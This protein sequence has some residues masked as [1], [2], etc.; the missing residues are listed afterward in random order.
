MST[1][2]RT[3]LLLLCPLMTLGYSQALRSQ[4]RAAEEAEIDVELMHS[5]Q[6]INLP[7]STTLQKGEMEF[8]I[9][10]RFLPLT[11]EGKDRFW[12]LDGPVNMRIGLGWALRNNLVAT[13]ARSNVEDN[14][15]L[16]VK[17]RAIQIRHDLFPI[18]LALQGGTSWN[19]EVIGR[20]KMDWK[21]VQYYGHLV[22]NTLIKKRL[23]LGFVPSYLYNSHI[24]CPHY[25][26]S[27]TLGSY[28]QFYLSPYISFL[29]EWNPTLDG[30]RDRYNPVSFGIEMETGGH[31]FKIVLTNSMVMNAS[32]FLAGA[33]QSAQ[34][35]DW[36]IGFMIT[37][38][39]KLHKPQ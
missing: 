11:S 32:Q 30:W 28:L 20:K 23:G 22:I 17:Y 31:F 9:S 27:F 18:V 21:N 10:H 15:D 38:L 25:Q 7:T 6:A 33:D 16:H 14:I 24:Y 5:Q 2:F 29:A 35:N 3:L 12:G 34:K 36:R 4:W 26:T 19:T 39:I 13:L 1:C 37:R 8:E